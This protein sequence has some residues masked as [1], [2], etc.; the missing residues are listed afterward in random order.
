MADVRGVV[1]VTGGGSCAPLGESEADRG[2]RV[3]LKEEVAIGTESPW[4]E[5]RCLFSGDDASSGT[6][7]DFAVE[8]G[9]VVPNAPSASEAGKTRFLV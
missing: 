3:L 1:S 5:V 4:I 9:G 8:G 6:L 2:R 7:P